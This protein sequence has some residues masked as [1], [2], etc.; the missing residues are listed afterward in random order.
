M[1]EAMTIEADTFNYEVLAEDFSPIPEFINAVRG[2]AQRV[3]GPDSEPGFM[4]FF[5]G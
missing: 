5:F 3:L 4:E 2:I 1:A